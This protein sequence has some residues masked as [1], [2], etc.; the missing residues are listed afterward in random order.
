MP[1]TDKQTFTAS[2][3]VAKS[4]KELILLQNDN[5][6]VNIHIGIIRCR[7]IILLLSF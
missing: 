4:T 7:D 6:K 1:I 2:K 3:S 5:A